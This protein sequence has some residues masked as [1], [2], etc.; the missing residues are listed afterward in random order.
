MRVD[1]R[2][3][4]SVMVAYQNETLALKAQFRMTLD[5]L[6]ICLLRNACWDSTKQ[7][8]SAGLP[9]ISQVLIMTFHCCGVDVILSSRQWIR[10]PSKRFMDFSF[11]YT[12]HK[13]VTREPT[14]NNDVSIRLLSSAIFYRN[15]LTF[16][17]NVCHWIR[18]QKVVGSPA[19]SI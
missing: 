17:P 13:E 12:R 3:L 5:F 18:L 15:L 6:S 9:G 8:S 19:S 16:T 10:N 1:L 14:N 2:Y 11:Y 4:C 7:R